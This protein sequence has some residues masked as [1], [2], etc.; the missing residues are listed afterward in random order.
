MPR[1]PQGGAF[2]VP[3]GVRPPGRAKTPWRTLAGA[4]IGIV[5][6]G[7]PC[8]PQFRF[9]AERHGPGVA[10]RSGWHMGCYA[11]ACSAGIGPVGAAR[12]DHGA[13]V[14]PRWGNPH[15]SE[16]LRRRPRCT[17]ARSESHGKRSERLPVQGRLL[18]LC[19]PS[20]SR[21]TKL[22]TGLRH[23]SW[24]FTFAQVQGGPDDALASVRNC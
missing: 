15:L 12:A 24:S 17:C 13:G 21:Q 20:I 4:A 10:R 11:S 7:G 23:P 2:E 9:N 8:T 22:Q 6:L 1:K 16:A 5:G 19:K 3:A 18:Q 14:G